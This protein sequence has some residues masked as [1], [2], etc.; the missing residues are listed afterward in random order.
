[1]LSNLEQWFPSIRLVGLDMDRQ[2]L[3][4]AR[5]HT[6]RSHLIRGSASGEVLPLKSGSCDV[7][8]VLHVV[9]HL[10][11]PDGFLK[12]A[13]RVLVPGGL[14][15]FATPNPVG[16]PARWMGNRWR[17]IRDDHVSLRAPARWREAL[18]RSGF[19]PDRDGTTGFSGIP[20]FHRTPLALLHWGPLLVWGAFPWNQG[21]AY[22]CWATAT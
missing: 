3:G 21:E 8:L 13:R 14:L 7:F 18:I 12:E 2:S 20:L 1:L 4:Y 11:E 10:E 22:V 17:G 9:E 16:F 6:R 15:M 5:Q 19:T